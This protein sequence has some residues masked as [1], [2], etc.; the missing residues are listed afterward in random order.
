M[1]KVAWA[2]EMR[3]VIHSVGARGWKTL[4]VML[5]C[6]QPAEERIFERYEGN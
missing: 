2:V 4:M 1:M 6:C 5:V 3:E